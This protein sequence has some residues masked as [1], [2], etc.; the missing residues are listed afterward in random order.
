MLRATSSAVSSSMAPFCAERSTN[1]LSSIGD[2]AERSSSCGS[3]PNDLTTP[4]ARPL[5]ARIGHAIARV[6]RRCG[7]WVN[8]AVA[9]GTARAMFFGMSSPTSIVTTVLATSATE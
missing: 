5:S 9:C 1:E 2:R 3:T 7:S 8:D 6:N 4:L